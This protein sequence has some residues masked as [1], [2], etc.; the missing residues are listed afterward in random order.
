VALKAFRIG[1]ASALA[2]SA[3]VLASVAPLPGAPP[4][5]FTGNG[6]NIHLQG[7][8][9]AAVYYVYGGWIDNCNQEIHGAP[10][11]VIGVYIDDS[12]NPNWPDHSTEINC[13]RS[14][15]SA[16]WKLIIAAAPQ[17]SPGWNFAK[18]GATFTAVEWYP[19]CG[20]YDYLGPPPK[21][22]SYIAQYNFTFDKT[23]IGLGSGTCPETPHHLIQSLLKK[24]GKNRPI[25]LLYY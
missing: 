9:H 10:G 7:G 8:T 3:A 25:L 2:G 18:Y 14:D 11:Q 19:Y 12:V 20:S 13:V 5:P 15:V 1:K 16:G 21:R 6:T 4:P 23:V 22:P 17:S 24:L